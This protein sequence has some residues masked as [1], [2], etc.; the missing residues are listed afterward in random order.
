[1]RDPNTITI[2]LIINKLWK[3][4]TKKEM[5]KTT[6]IGTERESIRVVKYTLNEKTAVQK[7]IKACKEQPLTIKME[8]GSNLRTLCSTATF[9]ATRKII[10]EA[11]R[12]NETFSII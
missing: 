12:E 1:M 2:L 11:I 8:R 7:K 3:M 9:E 6:T 4:M 10:E 5:K